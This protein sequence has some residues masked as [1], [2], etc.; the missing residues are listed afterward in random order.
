MKTSST[1]S[2]SKTFARRTAL[3]KKAFEK[4]RLHHA[5]LFESRNYNYLET[6]GYLLAE[7]ILNQRELWRQTDCLQLR[8]QGKTRRI[9]IEDTKKVLK[10]IHQSSLTERG[11]IIFI[12]HADR[13]GNTCGNALLKTLEE[14]P[15]RTTFFLLTTEAS[16]VLN[17][18]KSR[19]LHV[20]LPHSPQ[21][22]DAPAWKKW[23]EDYTALIQT[24]CQNPN[25]NL[26]LKLYGLLY[27]FEQ[28]LKNFKTKEQPTQLDTPTSLAW[29]AAERT[30]YRDRL[31]EDI[32]QHTY[33]AIPAE[34]RL[35][36][37]DTLENILDQLTQA[38][39]W[40]EANFNETAAL[41]YFLL[42]SLRLWSKS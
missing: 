41:E 39:K 2:N 21:K 7:C 16:A 40:T 11:K 35:N 1:Y 27:R 28:I 4:G 23:L 25:I 18:L 19:C 34:K 6:Q 9:N 37:L 20:P 36:K 15:P 29:Q 12:H 24:T 13:L 3:L 33:T 38:R 42:N 10:R 5:L 32:A 14:P 22:I 31:F 30:G 17:T 26:V 8:P